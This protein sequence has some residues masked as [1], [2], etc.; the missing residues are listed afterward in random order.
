MRLSRSSSRKGTAAAGQAMLE[1]ALT[2]SL[3]LLFVIGAMELGAT[4]FVFQSYADRARHAVRMASVKPYDPQ[5]TTTLIQNLILYGEPQIPSG[6]NP[7]R[8]F[9]G[10]ERGQI[11]VATSKSEDGD[12][13]DGHLTVRIAN[14]KYSLLSWALAGSSSAPRVGRT[15][16]FSHA[17]EALSD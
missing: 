17:Y 2:I 15:I 7:D 11:E 5:A 9:M 3:Y 10:L 13:S 8:G 4:L 14:Y 6:A 16:E 12:T 1:A